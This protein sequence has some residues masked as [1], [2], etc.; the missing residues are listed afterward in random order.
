MTEGTGGLTMT[1]PGDYVENSVGVPLPGVRVRLGEQDELMVA[2]PYVARYLPEEAAPGDLTVERP[3]ADDVWIGTGDLFRELPG[4][5]LQIVDRIKDIYK[6]NR[7]QTIAPRKVEAR[8]EGV[9]GITRTFLAGDGRAFNALLIVPDTAD[10]VLAKLSDQDR[11]DYFQRLIAQANLDLAPYERVVNFALLDRDFSPDH[12]ELTAKGSYRRKQIATNFAAVIDGLYRSDRRTL[13]WRD[14]AIVVPHWVLRDLGVLEEAIQ[15]APDGLV[16]TQRGLRLHLAPGRAPDWLVVGDLEYRLAQPEAPVDLGLFARQPLLWLGNPAL[17]AFLPGKDGWDHVIDSPLDQVTLPDRDEATV[18]VATSPIQHDPRLQQLDD[19]CRRAL[20]GPPDVALAALADVEARLP[21]VP[22][23]EAR[24]LRRR[25]EALAN[26]PVEAIRCRA[27]V[28]LILDQ[29]EPEYDR[30]FPAFLH[31]GKTFLSRESILE[32]ARSRFESRRLQSLRRRL[33]LYRTRLAWPASPTV[34]RRFVDLLHLLA[35][36]ARFNID[37]YLTVRRELACWIVFDR[38]PELA[39]IALQLLLDLGA[40]Y[41]EYQSTTVTARPDWAGKLSFQEGMAPA[42]IARIADVL[43]DTTFLQGSVALAFGETLDPA[44]IPAAGVWVSRTY[45]L[46]QPSHYRVSINTTGG[47]HYDLLVILRD[48]LHDLEVMRTFFW[49]IAL[50]AY[51]VG[52]PVMPRFGCLRP[53]LGAVSLAFSND[54]NV[55]ERVRL[56]AAAGASRPLDRSGWRKLLVAG[57]AT[58][59]TAWLHSDRR[60][61]PGM[62]TPSNVIVPDPSWRQDRVVISLGGWKPYTGPLSLIRPLLKNFLRLP[63]SHFPGCAPLLD[64]RWVL[65]A[66]AEA[67]GQGPAREFLTELSADLAREG[68]PEAGPGFPEHVREFAAQLAA[69]FRAPLA[70]ENAIDRYHEWRSVNPGASAVASLDQIEALSRLFHL[71]DLGEPTRLALFT[72]HLLRAPWP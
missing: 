59:L 37:Y 52:I 50:R 3:V 21:Q 39:E 56:H 31:S 25:L 22:P 69:T 29:P 28:I 34:R 36:F 16:D 35:D 42:E 63:A 65:E 5:H 23:H 47:S 17:A 60:I 10:P 57:M 58:V 24:L 30:Y 11:H 27:Y 8:F 7:G 45:A 1:P 61:I 62:V 9:P 19:L 48:D 70:L 51:P 44:E 13:R 15:A 72:A 41:E 55:W 66:V 14:R 43:T 38:D 2:G 46:P 49:V 20:F 26:H 64:D 12:D 32:I 71:D 67:L 40:W 18:A 54:L 4:G 6:N 33:H 53:D 68:L